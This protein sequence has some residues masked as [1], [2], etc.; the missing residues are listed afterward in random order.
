[1][2]R[3]VGKR[4]MGIHVAGVVV[5]V[6]SLAYLAL[7][8]RRVVG[9]R[10]RALAPARPPAVTIML[11]CHGAPPRLY[12]CLRSVCA[13]TY[14]GPLQAVFGLHD[15]ADPARAVI[16][17]LIADRP[18]LDARLVI[19]SRRLGA[20]PKNCNLANMM[21][22]ARHD[23]LVIVDSDV[24]VRPTFVATIV[25]PL[26]NPGVGGVTCLYK[27]APERGLASRLGALYMNDW[28][29]P[30]VLVD[31]G[32][33]PGPGI[34]YGAAAAITRDALERIGGFA[35][36]A[37][38]VAQDY[39][40]GHALRQ[41][42]YDIHLAPDVV[43]TTVTETSIRQLLRHEMRWMRAI[44]AVRPRDHALWILTSPLV[45]L[46]LLAMAWPA[47]IA[48]PAVLA[49]LTLRMA[50]HLTVRRHVALPA[51]EPWL[52]P[53]RDGLNF[54]LWAGSFLSRRVRWG[55][56]VLVTGGGL[57]MRDKTES[58]T[59]GAAGVCRA[60]TISRGNP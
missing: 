47:A 30:S 49:Y 34:T 20:N 59:P 28:F 37:D 52:V 18:D 42:G 24:L 22:A 21:A 54:V 12:E 10:E 25:A 9:F 31:I 33:R 17:R 36:M 45:P 13:Q 19:D 7:A 48:F 44:R 43:A 56:S 38:A 53:V 23:V 60:Q 35:A 14:G 15:A 16:E 2:P 40:L 6:A 4:M 55:R 26:D 3:E 51:P 27:G 1:M 29:I 58:A 57:T 46:G 50:L 11:P 5:F 8:F 41:A 39:V 32:G